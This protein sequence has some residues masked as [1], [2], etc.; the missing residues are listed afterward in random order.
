MYGLVINLLYYFVYEFFVNY[1]EQ[2][3]LTSNQITSMT[4]EEHYHQIAD[5]Q[6]GTKKGKM[7]GALCIKTENNGKAAAIYWK[8]H[9]VFKL[10]GEAASDALS[11]DGSTVFAPMGDRE[12][13]GW[14]QVPFDY[15]DQWETFAEASV[16]FVSSLPANKKKKKKK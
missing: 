9:M 7:F 13:K 11:L 5:K 12:M 10:Q 1:R 6:T 16:A 3:K 2:N 14:I 8:E 15:V 4:P